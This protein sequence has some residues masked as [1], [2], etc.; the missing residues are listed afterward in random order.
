MAPVAVLCRGRGESEEEREEMPEHD[1]APLTTEDALQHW[2][3]AERAVAVARRGRLA[4]EAAAA[5]AEEAAEAAQAT[6]A[7][8]KEALAAMALAETSATKTATAAKTAAL[9]ARSD[10][11]NATAETSLAEVDEVEAQQGYRDAA[12]RAAERP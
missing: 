12:R 2:R 8:A 4:A 6:A 11:L 3:T 5:A 1:T 7:A 9:A 10:V